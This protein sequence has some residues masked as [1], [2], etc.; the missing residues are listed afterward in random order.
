[1]PLGGAL[2]VGTWS[3]DRAWLDGSDVGCGV[4]PEVT[5]SPMDNVELEVGAFVVGGRGSSL[6]GA[7]DGTD[8][9]YTRVK[10]S[11]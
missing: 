2:E 4:F 9:V 5:Y 10:V 8:Q 1:M 11:F 7:W 6:F 3:G